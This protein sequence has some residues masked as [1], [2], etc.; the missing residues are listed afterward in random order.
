MTDN[1]AVLS[2]YTKE[3]VCVTATE[4][5]NLLVMPDAFYDDEFTAWDMNAQ[6][7][8]KVKG[9]LCETNEVEA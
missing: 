8:I 5:L 6:E 2:G 3:V 1:V 7:F 4:E 9:W